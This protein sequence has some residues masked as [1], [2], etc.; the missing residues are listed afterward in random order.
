MLWD[1]CIQEICFNPDHLIKSIKFFTL[2]PAIL[3]IILKRNDFNV[4]DEIIIWEELLKW[5]CKQQ[6]II[7]EDINKWDKMILQ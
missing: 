5:T 6:P 2:N 4:D 7:Q 1:F 3:E